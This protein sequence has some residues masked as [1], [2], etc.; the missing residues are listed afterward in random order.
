MS[1]VGSGQSCANDPF[2]FFLT[3]RQTT[4][5]FPQRTGI[6]FPENFSINNRTKVTTLGRETQFPAGKFE[7]MYLTFL[8]YVHTAL[9]F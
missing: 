9:Y 2:L 7:Y 5:V 4:V 6:E 1:V 8:H 3:V